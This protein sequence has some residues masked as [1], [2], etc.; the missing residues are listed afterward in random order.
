MTKFPGAPSPYTEKL[1]FRQHEELFKCFSL[2][3]EDGTLKEKSYKVL[4]SN[5][6]SFADPKK[7]CL[8]PSI[9]DE[10]LVNMYKSM[11]MIKNF[12]EIM[13]MAQR[14]YLCYVFFPVS[15]VQVFAFVL[16]C[17]RNHVFPQARSNSVLHVEHRRR[18]NTNWFSTVLFTVLV[19]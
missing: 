7:N 8:Q 17:L 12:D 10:T 9:P 5:F 15:C 6:S 11:V 4:V 1:E 3:R 2:M 14:F 16:N 18:S 19:R 13:L